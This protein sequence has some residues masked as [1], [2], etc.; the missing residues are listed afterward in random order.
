MWI[1]LEVEPRI[2]ARAINKFRVENSITISIPKPKAT[3]SSV[4]WGDHQFCC[5][6]KVT[7]SEIALSN[8]SKSSTVEYIAPAPEVFD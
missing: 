3:L 7:L 1:Q 2:P 5:F 8:F 4:F 6:S